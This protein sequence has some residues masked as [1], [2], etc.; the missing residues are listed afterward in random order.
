MLLRNTN[1][2][3]KVQNKE[4]QTSSMLGDRRQKGNDL[5]W[6]SGVPPTICF[7]VNG[8][9]AGVSYNLCF[10]CLNLFYS[11]CFSSPLTIG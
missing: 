5:E 8:S 10:S 4:G 3:V 1:T 2:V 11:S 7:L 9:E 6:T